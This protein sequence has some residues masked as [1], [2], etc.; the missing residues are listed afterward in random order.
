MVDL[1]QR[2]QLLDEIFNQYDV[3]KTGELTAEQL[4]VIHSDIRLGSISLPQV[5]HG[6][7]IMKHL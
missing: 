1:E 6:K 5:I 7:M 2:E 4:Q 3:F